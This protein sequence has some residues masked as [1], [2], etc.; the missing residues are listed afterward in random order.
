MTELQRLA[1]AA[2]FAGLTTGSVAAQGPGKPGDNPLAPG[3]NIVEVAVAASVALDEFEYLFA[4]VDCL[5]DA[6]GA[7]PIVAALTGSKRLTL[8]APTDSAFE[9]LQ[10]RLGI[11][12]PAPEKTCA[13]E[14]ETVAD[15]LTYHVVEGRR[16]SNSLFNANEPKIV[17]MLNGE[18]IETRPGLTITDAAGQ[19]VGVVGAY[20]NLNASNGVIHVIDTVLVPFPLP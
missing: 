12:E 19:S 18:T 9:A 6:D 4:A 10:R 1:A 8:F 11:D 5:T 16:F 15:V 14:Q 17:T 7:N 20:A 2:V 13:L 3:G